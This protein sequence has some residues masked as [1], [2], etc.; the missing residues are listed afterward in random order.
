MKNL[1][2]EQQTSNKKFKP[3]SAR[4]FNIYKSQFLPLN[5][6]DSDALDDL[7]RKAYE[8]ELLIKKQ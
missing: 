2:P 4:N 6:N 7:L 8:Y 5:A 1:K 3:S